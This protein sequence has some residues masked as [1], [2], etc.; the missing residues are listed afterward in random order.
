MRTNREGTFISYYTKGAALALLLDLK[1]RAATNGTRSLDDVLRL[2]K[3]RTWDARSTS[4][5]LQG[6]GYT[7]ADVERAASDVIG[8]DLHPWFER[9]AGGTQELPWA[10]SL[11]AVGVT[12]TVREV[13]ASNGASTDGDGTSAPVAAPVQRQYLLEDAPGATPAQVAI[14]E[15]WLKG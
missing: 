9:Y 3:T 8:Q 15:G 2:L 10:E 7:E 11:A 5:Y 6:R 12:L 14:R 4:Y 13:D 1:I